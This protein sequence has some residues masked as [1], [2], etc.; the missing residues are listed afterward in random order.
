MRCAA[1]LLT[2]TCTSASILPAANAYGSNLVAYYALNDGTGF[3]LRESV[4]NT[5][6]AGRVLYEDEHQTVNYTQPNWVEDE[7]FGM[8]ISCGDNETVQ[9]DTLELA[10][11]DYGVNG[12]FTINV[13]YRHHEENFARYQKEQFFG[14][15][16]P[17]GGMA[18]TANGIHVMFE[19]GGAAYEATGT[20]RT[21]LL[22]SNDPAGAQFTCEYCV[23]LGIAHSDIDPST[24]QTCSQ[25]SRCWGQ[26][27]GWVDTLPSEHGAI[28]EDGMWHMYTITTHPAGGKGYSVYIDGA[29]RGSMP[30]ANAGVDNMDWRL[31][32]GR[33]HCY[34]CNGTNPHYL[35]IFQDRT[36]PGVCV[37]DDATAQVL[38]ASALGQTLP[39]PGACAAIGAANSPTTPY[40]GYASVR[41]ACCVTCGPAGGRD[42]TPERTGPRAAE[43]AQFDLGGDPINPVG[44]MRFC[45]RLGNYGGATQ[46]HWADEVLH[47]AD[48]GW[49]DR[50]Y[51]LGKVAHA[52]FYSQAMSEAQI[53]ALM[54]SYRE[55]Y[56]RLQPSPP[57][58]PSPSAAPFV[59]MHE[60]FD[61][62]S[63]FTQSNL[64]G[65]VAFF[66]DGSSEYFGINK[67]NGASYF[68]CPV[69]M[70]FPTY[71]TASCPTDRTTWVGTD[72]VPASARAYTGFTGAYIEATRVHGA[73]T[74]WYSAAPFILTW[75][76]S[77]SCSGTLIFSGKFAS[78]STGL[79]T[80]DY[81]RVQAS[82][83]GAAN[84]TVLEFRGNPNDRFAVDTDMDGIGDGTLLGLS[85]GTFTATIPGMMTSSVVLSVALR[86]SSTSEDI[87]ADD[88]MLTCG[89]TVVSPPP[90]PSHPTIGRHARCARTAPARTP[91]THTAHAHG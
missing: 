1:L 9:K 35:P 21:I 70:T 62:P 87:A 13:W 59:S 15:G 23:S 2:A 67:G 41:S 60:T 50:R 4:S 20:I 90:P 11:V 38:A 64:L 42:Y 26:Y 18:S 83:D 65:P 51:F 47:N 54:Q 19:K 37:D 82:V 86:T 74:T 16:D 6:N 69:P 5:P 81:V 44:P 53:S 63:G 66:V 43:R 24:N 85:A 14:H 52:S 72:N 79:E 76:A 40:C 36:T 55:Q 31:R 27:A 7:Y 78:E 45:G 80:D 48:L 84:V 22:D 88:I 71:G 34:N 57:P 17:R 75:S 58:S 39:N 10:D 12:A 32:G 8:V 28:D 3:D 56:P 25:N 46:G 77:G 89:P 73:G 61:S 33:Y 30:F 91:R 68:S 49:A 29:L